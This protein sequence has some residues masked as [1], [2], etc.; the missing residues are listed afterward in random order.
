M[1][2]FE[3]HITRPI[4]FGRFWTAVFITAGLLWCTF[5]TLINIAT[6][7]YEIVPITS[8]SFNYPYHMWYENIFPITSWLPAARSC[9]PSVIRLLEGLNSS[10]QN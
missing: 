10:P 6:V 2:L 4:R 3:Y 8:T 7:G 9:D 1:H 5:V